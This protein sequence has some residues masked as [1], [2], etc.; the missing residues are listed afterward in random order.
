MA[1]TK[2]NI[3]LSK[4][5]PGATARRN[6]AEEVL[7]KAS[8]EADSTCQ[9]V[10]CLVFEKLRVEQSLLS[11]LSAESCLQSL[12]SSFHHVLSD[13]QLSPGVDGNIVE[14]SQVMRVGPLPTPSKVDRR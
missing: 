11:R 8:C 14:G 6:K 10:T 13:T 2:R 3:T 4:P 1:A 7:E 5:L 9:E 12:S